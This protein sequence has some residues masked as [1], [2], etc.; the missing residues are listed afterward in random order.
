MA[1]LDRSLRFDRRAARRSNALANL[2]TSRRSKRSGSSGARR[3]CL[4]GELLEARLNLSWAGAPPPSI[5]LPTAATAVV[6]NANDANGA[7]SIA[8]TEVDYYAFTAGEGG[9]YT[10]STSTPA[11]DVDTVLGVF[12]ASGLRLAYNDDISR[13]NSDSALSL[14]L[15]A[16][17]RYFLGVTNYSAA[18]RGA[19]NW[20]IDGPSV[21]PRLPTIFTRITTPWPR[22]TISARSRP[23]GRSVR[24]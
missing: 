11:S 5:A 23:S 10:I 19:Y 2:L 16:G 15:S 8:S 6:L 17:A 4:G 12:S 24:W 7:A 22:R 20:S 9:T 13:T 21:A 14:S 3:R 1:I 18:T